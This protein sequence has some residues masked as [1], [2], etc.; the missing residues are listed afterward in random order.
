MKKSVFK[1]ILAGIIVGAALFFIPFFLLRGLLLFFVISAIVR[2]AIFRGA[3][4]RGR[5]YGFYGHQSV[6]D[7]EGYVPLK[8]KYNEM[9]FRNGNGKETII[10]I[11]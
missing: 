6:W 8:Q 10:V 7:N 2:L 5:Y 3:Q 4:R 9:N 11:E 1:P